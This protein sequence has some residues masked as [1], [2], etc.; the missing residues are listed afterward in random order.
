MERDLQLAET[1]TAWENEEVPTPFARAVWLSKA[2]L[3]QAK[4]LTKEEMRLFA[5]E[6]EQAKIREIASFCTNEA[7]FARRALSQSE[8]RRDGGS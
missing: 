4:E 5:W 6:V 2:K 7:R 3:I 1:L 8:R